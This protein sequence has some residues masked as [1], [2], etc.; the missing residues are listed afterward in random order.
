MQKK[1]ITLLLTFLVVI[2]L[3]AGLFAFYTY[4]RINHHA[5]Y[6]L[7][8][9][10]IVGYTL[11]GVPMGITLGHG[12]L[13][14]VQIFVISQHGHNST[15]VLQCT[16]NTSSS[17]YAN[18]TSSYTLGETIIIHRTYQDSYSETTANIL[19]TKQMFASAPIGIP[20][21]PVIEIP[22]Q[23]WIPLTATD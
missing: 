17:W 7:D 10:N 20:A 16:I 12:Q 23:Q 4:S 13:M 14:Q 9:N 1:I 21:P 15:K 3:V 5:S 19:L 18:A 22:V 6:Y 2:A 8:L 11:N